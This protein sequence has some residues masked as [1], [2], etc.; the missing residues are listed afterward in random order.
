MSSRARS[1][2]IR[3]RSRGGDHHGSAVVFIALV[4]AVLAGMFNNPY[5]G[6]V[7]FIAVPAVF[8][9][10]LL[11][12]PAG[13]AGC[14][15]RKLRRRP[16][17]RRPDW[18]VLDFR[19]RAS[20]EPPCSSRRSPPSTSSS[21]CSP[22]TARCTRWNRPSF[23]GQ[24]CHTP[25]HPQ[26]TAWQDAAHSSVACVAVS[27]RRRGA[28]PGARQACRRAAAGARRHQQLSEADSWRRSST[29]AR[30]SKPAATA[31]RPTLGFGDRIRVI[32]EYA[33]DEANTETMTE[34]QMHVGGP[35][36]PRHRAARSTGTRI[37]RVRV[38]YIATDAER[39][40]DS[41]RAGD[42]RARPGQGIRRR[43]H[44]AGRPREGARRGRWTAS[45]ATTPWRIAS[46]RRRSRP[47]IAPSPRGRLTARCRSS[48]ARACDW[49]RPS[50]TTRMR[51]WRRSTVV[52]AN[53][54]KPGTPWMPRLS[55]SRFAASKRSIAATSSLRWV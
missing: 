37:L 51:R 1:P 24:T 42:Q 17:R 32:R 18:P 48:V 39:A 25:M 5:A 4:I 36:Q 40:D 13:H 30:R 7:V 3:S 47:S 9:L 54:T 11:L 43:G 52:C 26:F 44:Y 12:I 16:R 53:S 8:V 20:A 28:G 38:E 45:I 19:G 31:T 35:G 33:D 41:V 46:R 6:L 21:C 29:C 10:G 55:S 34:L 22:D 23:C 49:S 2:A 15:R 14:E 27:H 50:T